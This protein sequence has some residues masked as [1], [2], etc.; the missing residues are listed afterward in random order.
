MLLPHMNNIVRRAL[1]VVIAALALLL[2]VALFGATEI[3]VVTDIVL[4]EPPD[5][6]SS[7]ALASDGDGYLAVWADFRASRPALIATRIRST[8]E[9]LDPTGIFIA[10]H[11]SQASIVWNGERY[12]VFFVG[13]GALRMRT[14]DR[15]GVIS[16][17]LMLIEHVLEAAMATNGSRILV[18]YAGDSQRPG[19]HVAALD[20]NG[21]VLLDMEVDVRSSGGPSVAVLPNGSFVAGWNTFAPSIFTLNA[22]RFDADGTRAEFAPHVLGNTYQQATLHANGDALVASEPGRCWGVSADLRDLTAQVQCPGG[23]LF[24]LRGRAALA[25]AQGPRNTIVDLSVSV[26]DEQGHAIEQKPL[27]KAT[28]REDAQVWSIAAIQKGDDVLIAWTAE[29]WNS[30][31]LFARVVSAGSL[32]PKGERVPLTTSA[33]GQLNP[34]IAVGHTEMLVAWEERGE[35]YAS[36]ITFDGRRL[37]GTGIRLSTNWAR[38]PRVVFHEGLYAVA[39][40]QSDGIEY[41]NL[42]VRFISPRDGLLPETVTTYTRA[43]ESVALASGGGML[44]AFT[45]GSRDVVATRIH[46]AGTADPA[47]VVAHRDGVYPRYPVASWNGSHFLVAWIESSVTDDVWRGTIAG[48]RVTLNLGIDGDVLALAAGKEVDPFETPA[49][50]SNGGEW[51]L[52][53]SRENHVRLARIAADGTVLS[54]SPTLYGSAPQLTFAG[55]QLVLAA[56]SFGNVTI[57]AGDT[58]T[59]IP[60]LPYDGFSLTSRAAKWYT[61]FTRRGGTEV[62][63]VERVYVASPGPRR[64][65]LR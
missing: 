64:R 10:P 16:G 46:P 8:G 60:S 63:H 50:A 56:K 55:R 49:L 18:S 4:N 2:S 7:L 34:S 61:A 5:S 62:G 13:D 20:M 23:R 28:D 32:E 65:T 22:L 48:R 24:S 15:D 27:F 3:P 51:F 35:V 44:V 54:E 14:I 40:L 31:R 33:K 29:H 57:Q 12:L 36:R 47:V 9:V 37:D 6:R 26:F 30:D 17:P 59:T 43:A 52:A 42:A 58:F 19:T 11:D 53:W 41:E 38:R 45:T 39:F 25:S 21:G 1:W